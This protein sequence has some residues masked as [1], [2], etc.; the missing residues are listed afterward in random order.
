LEQQ[1]LRLERR[2]L[3]RQLSAQRLARR[4]EQQRLRLEHRR[5]RA[6]MSWMLTVGHLQAQSV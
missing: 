3:L 2:L 5:L 1:R 4:L 6:K